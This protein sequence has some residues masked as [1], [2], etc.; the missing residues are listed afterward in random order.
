[1]DISTTPITQLPAQVREDGARGRRLY[2][3]A[4]GFESF[5]V[6]SLAAGLT[7]SI[8]TGEDEESDA[9]SQAA[10]GQLPDALATAIQSNGG[11]GLADQL[12]DNLRQGALR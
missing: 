4:L 9:T 11:L 1:M 12:Y 6:K 5:L 8:G 2:E 10:E 3:A 7:Q